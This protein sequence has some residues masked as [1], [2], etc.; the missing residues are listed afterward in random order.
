MEIEV[1]TSLRRF[2]IFANKIG[3]TIPDVL[4]AFPGLEFFD[5]EGNDIGGQPL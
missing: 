5:V 2:D 3:G 4:T 1:L